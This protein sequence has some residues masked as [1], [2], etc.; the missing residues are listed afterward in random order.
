MKIIALT[1]W[2]ERISPVFETTNQFLLVE[3]SRSGIRR[4][5]HYNFT[6]DLQLDRVCK[7]FELNVNVLVCGAISKIFAN[8]IKAYGIQLIP[9]HTGPVEEVLEAYLHGR[10]FS[11]QYTMPGC[12]RKRRRRGRHGKR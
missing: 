6:S 3:V 5:V 2:G 12:Q 10:M 4:Q 8:M 1:V 11:P 7:L 9:F